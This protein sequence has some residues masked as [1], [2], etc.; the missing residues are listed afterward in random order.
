MNLWLTDYMKTWTHDPS[1]GPKPF[2]Q[3]IDR[4]RLRAVTEEQR[5]LIMEARLEDLNNIRKVSLYAIIPLIF[6]SF[7]GGYLLS[8]RMLKPL[9]KL[10]IEMTKRNLENLREKIKYIDNGDEISSLIL[11]FNN[12]TERLNLAFESQRNFVENASHE[13]KT[14]LSVIQATIENALEDDKLTYKEIELI[15]NN[16]KKQI[17]FINKLTEDLLLLAVL[18]NHIKTEDI[19]FR[20]VIEITVN[21]LKAVIA[22]SKMNLKLS[23]GNKRILIKA[24]QE[25]LQRALANIVENSI[26]YSGGTKLDIKVITDMARNLTIVKFT[27]DGKGIPLEQMDK[28]FERFYRIDKGRSKKTGGSGLGLAIT[29]EIIEAHGGEVYVSKNHIKGT[30]FVIEL[31][32]IKEQGTSNN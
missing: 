4:P 9:D 28:V 16:I 2:V 18:K 10:N 24:N 6:I 1:M 12:M 32:I 8:S 30:Q 15:L 27:D 29:K 17:V 26:K 25:L 21:N 22:K 20:K 14:P 11:S 3:V 31:P 13:I 19:D 5:Q 23:M 7:G